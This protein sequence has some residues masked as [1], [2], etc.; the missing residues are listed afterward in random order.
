[1]G[2]TRRNCGGSKKG[3][4]KY[5][6]GV[7]DKNPLRG[8]SMTIKLFFDDDGLYLDEPVV[9]KKQEKKTANAKKVIKDDK[10]QDIKSAIDGFLAKPENKDIGTNVAEFYVLADIGKATYSNISAAFDKAIGIFTAE[11]NRKKGRGIGTTDGDA[12]YQQYIDALKNMKEAIGKNI[13]AEYNNGIY[14]IFL[15]ELS[16]RSDDINNLIANLKEIKGPSGTSNGVFI[17]GYKIDVFDKKAI[18]GFLVSL[19]KSPYDDERVKKAGFS[20]KYN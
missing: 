20:S 11:K 19:F 18:S 9:S 13:D 17:R 2:K 7:S 5:L 4:R 1:M 6:G 12:K 10:T 15:K 14:P 16:K 8:K 3:T